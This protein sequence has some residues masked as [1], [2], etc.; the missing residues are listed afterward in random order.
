MLGSNQATNSG[1][2]FGLVTKQRVFRYR[3]PANSSIAFAKGWEVCDPLQYTCTKSIAD[4]YVKQ[5]SFYSFKRVCIALEWVVR[6][7]K[8]SNIEKNDCQQSWGWGLAVGIAGLVWTWEGCQLSHHSY[9]CIKCM[10][11][12]WILMMNKLASASVPSYPCSSE[13]SVS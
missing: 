7:D 5:L 12:T 3:L 8:L 2:C 10:I 9:T 6:L 1:E 13:R 11:Y 4:L